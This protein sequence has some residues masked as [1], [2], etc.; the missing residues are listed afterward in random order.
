M[1]YHYVS[2]VIAVY[3]S[4]IMLYY[5]ESGEVPLRLDWWN[6]SPIHL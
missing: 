4:A 2:H 5:S 1:A 3:H 6:V